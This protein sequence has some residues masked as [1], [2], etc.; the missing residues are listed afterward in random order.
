[1]ALT[2]SRI[3]GTVRNDCDSSVATSPPKCRRGVEVETDIGAPEPIDR[4]LRVTDE[5]EPPWVD[6]DLL[7]RWRI[8]AGLAGS[9]QYRQLDLDGIGV[10]E[11]VE[12]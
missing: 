3:V 12:Q 8:L 1:M 2:Q 4:L 11:L 10:L 6:V 5:E 7:P 9:E